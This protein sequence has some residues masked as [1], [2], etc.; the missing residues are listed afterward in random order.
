MLPDISK[1]TFDRRKSLLP[2]RLRYN[3][4]IYGAENASSRNKNTLSTPQNTIKIIGASF[5]VYDQNNSTLKD[6]RFRISEHSNII[7]VP[8]IKR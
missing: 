2:T 5:Q 8:V 4:N 7:F 1:H 6:S 3:D